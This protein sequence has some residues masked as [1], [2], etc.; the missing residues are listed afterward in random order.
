MALALVQ[1][2][3]N[4][5]G[6]G[7]SARRLWLARAVGRSGLGCFGVAQCFVTLGSLLDAL[8]VCR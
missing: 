7:C 6:V 4:R 5:L 8:C 3:L 1:L 2:V